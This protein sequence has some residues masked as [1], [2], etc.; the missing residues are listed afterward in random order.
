MLLNHED[1]LFRSIESPIRYS[2]RTGYTLNRCRQTDK[3]SVT[4]LRKIS[5][6]VEDWNIAVKENSSVSVTLRLVCAKT[7]LVFNS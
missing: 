1:D 7:H 6:L 4:Y 2:Y 5:T 3:K